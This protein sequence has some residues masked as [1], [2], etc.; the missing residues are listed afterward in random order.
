M[1]TKKTFIFA[2]AFFLFLGGLVY[3]SLALFSEH[4]EYKKASI[5]YWML[6]PKDIS[7]I[8]KLCTDVP[9]FSYSAADGAKPLV[10]QLKCTAIN[11]E[12]VGYFEREGFVKIDA[13]NYK[14]DEK[15]VELVRNEEGK[16]TMATLLVFL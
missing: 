15:A 9:A 8:A 11:S 13:D 10:V 3:S 6:T 7:S 4:R 14:R 16:V 5:D 1:K 2:L 12:V